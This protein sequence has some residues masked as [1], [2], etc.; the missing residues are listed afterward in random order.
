MNSRQKF[1]LVALA[2][3]ALGSGVTGALNA[4]TKPPVYAVIDISETTDPE[5][6]TK[7]VTAAEP[8]ATLSAGGLSSEPQIRCT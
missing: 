7:A 2:G 8:K 5:A 6:Y 3:A 1:A 4:Q